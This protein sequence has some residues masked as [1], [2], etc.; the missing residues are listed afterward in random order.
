MKSKIRPIEMY[1]GTHNNGD[2]GSWHTDYVEIPIDTPES[3]IEKVSKAKAMDDFIEVENLT[4]VGVYFIMP[5]EE[6]D[7][8]YEFCDDEDN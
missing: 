3:D 2:Y 7:E 1:I 6:V 5:L 4:F 8:Y